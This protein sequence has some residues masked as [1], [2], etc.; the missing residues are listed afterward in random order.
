MATN[1]LVVAL[2]VWAAIGLVQRPANAAFH[3][4]QIEQV[5]GGVNGDPNAQAIQLRMRSA[6]QNVMSL[7][8][9]RAWDAAGTNPVLLVDMT[10]NVANSVASSRVLITTAKFATY[11]N[12][13]LV[14]DFTM[15]PIPASYLPAGRLTFEDD[16][17]TIYWSLAWG[18]SSYT[19]SNA[20]SVQNDADG[21]YGP[22]VNV[23]LPSTSTS[24]LLINRAFNQPSTN[25]LANYGVT[26]GAATFTNNAGPPNATA[27]TGTF[28]VTI[29][30]PPPDSGDFDDDDDVDGVDFL[31]WQQFAGGPGTFAQGDANHDGQVDGDDLVIWETQYA[32]PPPLS[33]IA[34]VPE[35]HVLVLT[36]SGLMAWRRQRPL[37]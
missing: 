17:G 3:V 36:L 24:A 6:G 11:T 28:V 5:I 9:L 26:A 4:M 2:V 15:A 21:N 13:P 1:R 7:S 20:G 25:N 22:P 29:P 30:A 12:V 32:T 16:F 14:S 8:R 10:T 34:A 23:A 18:G 27:P 37:G 35:P 33:G 19:G 31:T